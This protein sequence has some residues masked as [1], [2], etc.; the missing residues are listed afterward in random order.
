MNQ[1]FTQLPPKQEQP[2]INYNTGIF[3]MGS[4]FVDNIGK[5][6]AYHKFQTTINPFGI[7]F[8]PEAIHNLLKRIVE[9]RLFTT[10]DIF[11]HNE[12][13]HCFEVHSELSHPNKDEFI[14][15][16]NKQL[17]T[18]L[19]QLK[20]ASH[21]VFTF[22]TA[23]NYFHKKNN[24]IVANC[25]K[26][27]QQEFDKQLSSV[28]ELEIGFT[29]CFELIAQ[30]NPKAQIITTI[31]PVRHIKDGIIENNRSKANLLAALHQS[32]QNTNTTYYP[33]YE[34]VM[35]SLRDYRFYEADLIHPNQI[36]IDFIWEHFMQTWIHETATQK[37]LKRIAEIQR[38]LQHRPFNIE[39]DAHQKF[40]ISLQKKID[41]LILEFPFLKF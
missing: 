9:Q 3:L 7:I 17:K 24:Q 18:S 33:A 34:L 37:T 28:A 11:Y 25:H 23:W 21:V 6:L 41:E 36:A 29:N 19:K 16:L 27:P 30:L 35:D 22:G 2:C 31:S 38:G 1:F 15:T 5:K 40:T 4:C 12:Q 26:I 14:T 20:T 8:H 10:E 32:I 39:S 13:W